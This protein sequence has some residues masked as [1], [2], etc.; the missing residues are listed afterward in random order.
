MNRWLCC[1]VLGS[2]WCLSGAL[3]A[4]QVRVRIDNLQPQGGYYFTP[5]WMGFHDGGFDLF[6]SG[7]LASVELSTIAEVGDPGP[8]EN[9]FN[10]SSTG[11]DLVVG[12][13]L[14]FAA[15]VFEPQE[16]VE[17]TVDVPLSAQNRYLSFASMVI[18]SNDAFFGNSDPMAYQVFGADGRLSSPL[19]IEIR[20]S[21]VYDAGSEVNDGLGAAFSALG[22]SSTDELVNIALHPGLDNFLNTAT[23]AGT[24]IT[25]G[26]GADELI[27]RITVTAVPE[28]TQ[29]GLASVMLG[30]LAARRRKRQVA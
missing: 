23:A 5:V 29:L 7:A 4:E 3:Q 11:H 15:P 28:P 8:L 24:M 6:N 2:S 13:P 12:A 21:S 26:L 14:G 1:A 9:L 25:D 17:L 19:V 10:A 27:A 20:R 22:G 18:P 30:L 16:T